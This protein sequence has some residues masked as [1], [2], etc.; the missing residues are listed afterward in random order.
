MKWNYLPNL[1]TILRIIL[2]V[3][4]CYN[5]V[6]QHFLPALCFLILAGLSDGLDGYLARH[7]NWQTRLGSLLDPIADKLMVISCFTALAWVKAIP[8][9]LFIIILLKD[10]IVVTGAIIYHFF[11]AP[12]E[13][14]A[15]ILSKLNTFLQI[16]FLVVVVT[17]MQFVGIPDILILSLMYAM[18]ATTLGSMLDYV[19]VWSKKAY[20]HKS[21][22]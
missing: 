4:V 6:Q 2:I 21:H 19:W 7:F 22:D 10:I 12:Y 14:S 9:W 5:I 16:L 17:K 15:T 13:F 20:T 11:I 3:P 1:I 8:F 18:L